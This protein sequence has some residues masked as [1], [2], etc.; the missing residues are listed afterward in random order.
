MCGIAGILNLEPSAPVDKQ[1][2]IKMVSMLHHRGP[3]GYGYY[4]DGEIG[5]GHSRLSIIDLQG[6]KQPIHNEDQSVWVTF[7]GE[8]FNYIELMDKLKKLGHIFYTQSDTEVIVHLYEEYGEKFVEHLNGQFAIAL[9]DKPKKKLM[10]IRD[11]VGILPLYYYKD[12]NRLLFASEIK[13]LIPTMGES[14]SLNPNALDQI[15]TFWAPISPQTIFKNVFEVSPGEMLIIKHSDIKKEKYW[16]WVYSEDGSY[17]TQSVDELAE[18]LRDLLV[19]AIKIR[20]R[21]DVPVGAYLSGGLDSSVITT[22]I[23]NF[24]TNELRTFSIGFS[25]KEFDE[26]RYQ[27]ELIKYLGADHSSIL[28]TNKDI[29]KNF[30]RTIWH[31]ET[32]ILRTAPVPMG[33][34]SGLVHSKGYKVVL[35]GEGSDEVLGGYDIFKE[36]KI[37]LFWSKFPDS[38]IRPLLLKKLYPYLNISK[39]QGLEY[40]QNFYGM[41]LDKANSPYF[42]H[43]PRW[44]TTSKCKEFFS[45]D[46]KS[47]LSIEAI[48]DMEN[49]FPEVLSRYRPFEQWQYI[50]SKSLMSGYL[51]CSQGDRMLMS[52]SIEG[53]F[54]FLDH[55][56]IEFASQIHPKNKMKGL[57]EKYLLKKAMEQSLPE[58]ITKRYKQPYRAPDIPS[59]FDNGGEQYVL[60]LLSNDCIKSYGYFDSKRVDLLLKKIKHG[61]AIS[62][63][64][65]MTFVGILSTQVWHNLFIENFSEAAKTNFH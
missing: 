60:E 7:N 36:A 21:A 12:K 50:E 34:L 38:E 53:R 58:S 29:A 35:T 56:V 16:D 19:D 57:N 23:K 15:F 46:L 22:L 65:N 39:G 31:G 55:R 9:W 47:Q 44:T 25:E 10:L 54:P 33:I 49:S 11:R 41:G 32:P 14:P 62:Y 64:D 20:L 24:T 28:C 63:K 1:E 8:I 26:T 18:Q 37:R 59:F 5:L 2:L 43:I 17:L 6:G 45:Q 40:L 51:L 61:R 52:H 3:D 4:V 13:G 30:K 48:V 27:K 42:A